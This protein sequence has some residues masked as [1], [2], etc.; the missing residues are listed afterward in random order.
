MTISKKLYSS[1]GSAILITMILGAAGLFGIGSIQDKITKCIVDAHKVY[2]TGQIKAIALQMYGDEEEMAR[3]GALQDQSSVEKYN[4]DFRKI[5]EQMRSYIGENLSLAR[6]EKGKSI[7]RDMQSDMAAILQNHEDLYRMS[8][9][10]DVAGASELL[11]NKVLSP[12]QK[13]VDGADT[14]V[15]LAN[16]LVVSSGVDA[17]SIVQQTRLITAILLVLSIGIGAVLVGVVRHINLALS[18][19][20]V[21]LSE[22]AVQIASAA[23]QVASS[24]QSLAQGSSEQAASLEETSSTTE[25]IN[26]MA[27]RN[28]ENSGAM[29]QLVA[30]SQHQFVSTNHQLG[31]METAMDEINLSSGKISKIIKVIDDIAFQTNILALNAAV[32]AARAGEAG[33]GFSVVAEEV[34]NLA[35]RSAQAAKDT[36][37]LIEESIGKSDSGKHKVALVATAIRQMTADF[38]KIKT[39]VDEVSQGSKQQT[40]G[41]GQVRSALS[42]M[43]QVSQ[44]TAAGAEESAAAA[45]Q[46]NAQS[47][48]LKNIVR[49]LSS[50]VG[51]NVVAES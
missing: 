22:G 4:D 8:K 25:E 30:D 48:A 38:T 35:Q 26:S 40:D 19:S 17:G 37:E 12:V 29:S 41:I 33:M 44:G 2:L 49:R 42:Q 13:I 20:L 47:E 28:T 6:T 1:S 36:S 10:G 31:E 15:G 18:T 16:G 21:E 14:I 5:S 3:R 23:A 39:L 11:T 9:S 34:R 46:M 7:S 50:M 27:G 32:E 24:S 51:V 45:E 43:E